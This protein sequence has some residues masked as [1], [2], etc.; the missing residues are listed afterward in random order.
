EIVP[1]EELNRTVVIAFSWLGVI[2][3]GALVTGA[4]TSLP[5]FSVISGMVSAVGNMGPSFIP[6]QGFTGI[7]PVIKVFYILG[8][9]A[10]RLE[11]LPILLI[12]SR[13]VWR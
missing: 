11:I 13:R 3:V 10:G 8:M 6:R 1:R 7:S 5:A 12:F 9:V 4:F 2:A